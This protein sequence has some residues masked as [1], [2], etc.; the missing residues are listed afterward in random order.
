MFLKT[1][2]IWTR[3]SSELQSTTFDSSDADIVLS[4]AF[5]FLH[6]CTRLYFSQELN[7]YG[8]LRVNFLPVVIDRYPRGSYP[9]FDLEWM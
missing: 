2:L 4:E 3:Y 5:K 6:T 7:L 1:F 9:I 8:S